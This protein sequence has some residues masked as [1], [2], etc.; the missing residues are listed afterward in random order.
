[1]D[2]AVSPTLRRRRRVRRWLILAAG[3]ITLALIT[4]GL[5]RLRPAAPGVEKASLYLGTVERGEMLRQVRGNG[6]LVPED[7]RWIPTINAGR[8]ERIKVLPGARVEADTVLVELSNP[9]VDQAA[10]DAEWQLKGA[11]ADLANT[12]VQMAS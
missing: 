8:V 12:R 10:F 6:V 11:E 9:D 3:G 5:S 2:V 1:M 7:I 4:F